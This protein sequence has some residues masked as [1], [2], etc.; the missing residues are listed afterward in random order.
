[1]YRVVVDEVKKQRREGRAKS[2]AL[3]VSVA[4]RACTLYRLP[5]QLLKAGSKFGNHLYPVIAENFFVID[6]N[7]PV[8]LA[9]RSRL[10]VETDRIIVHV[11]PF[12]ELYVTRR[13]QALPQAFV[14]K[15]AQ[16]ARKEEESEL[17][18]YCRGE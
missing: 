14:C 13:N 18:A 5:N 10:D 2:H 11:G 12:A 1:M 4:R 7:D 3:S 6:F 9:L 17:G 16:A 8:I 15:R